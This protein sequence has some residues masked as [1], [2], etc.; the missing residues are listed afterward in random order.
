M[1]NNE[2]YFTNIIPT[3]WIAYLTGSANMQIHTQLKKFC[4]QKSIK[5]VIRIDKD[6]DY[7]HKS[8][9]YINEIKQ[10]LLKHEIDLL[11]T[12]CQDKSTILHNNYLNGVETLIISD[13]RLELISCLVITFLKKYADMTPQQSFSAIQTKLFHPVELSE[14]MQYMLRVCFT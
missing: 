7:W 3:V 4:D 5:K 12:Y 9:D 14:E 10:N 11:Y 1:E 2:I 8:R 13:R 6:I